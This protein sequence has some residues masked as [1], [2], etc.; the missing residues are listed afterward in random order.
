MID[1]SAEEFIQK[2]AEFTI[3]VTQGFAEV[4]KRAKFVHGIVAKLGAFGD[5]YWSSDGSSETDPGSKPVFAVTIS[6]RKRWT[7]LSIRALRRGFNNQIHVWTYR[8]D[9][10]NEFAIDQFLI[11]IEDAFPQ[12]ATEARR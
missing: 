5:V 11:A 8:L 1:A 9:L 10:T 12:F 2:S 3:E 7:S 4:A 6:D